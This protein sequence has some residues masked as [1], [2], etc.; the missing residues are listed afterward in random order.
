MLFFFIFYF[1]FFKRV[2]TKYYALVVLTGIKI[3][4]EQEVFVLYLC[5]HS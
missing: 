2:V 5:C 4:L 1:L 3:I